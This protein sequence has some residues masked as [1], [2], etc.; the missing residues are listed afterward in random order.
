M[1]TGQP[2][3]WLYGWR[4]KMKSR[5]VFSWV[6][7]FCLSMSF[8]H[9]FAEDEQGFNLGQVVVTGTKTEHTLGEVPVAVDVVT[10]EDIKKRNVKTV[11][12]ALDLLTGLRVTKNSSSWGDKGH[13][14]MQG[15]DAKHTLVLIDGQRFTGGHGDAV[16]LQQI[17][18]DMI[19]RIEVVKG[20]ASALYG[21][22][23]VG[24]VVNVITKKASDKPFISTENLIGTRSTQKHSVTAGGSA[25]PVGAIV[26]YTYNE[27][28][29]VH[30]ETDKYQEHI[31]HG[32]VHYDILPEALTLTVKPYYSQHKQK[33]ERRKQER[34]GL[35]SLLEWSP[36]ELSKM[37]MRGSLLHY[38]HWDDDKSSNWDEDI[39]EGEINYSR[40]LFD[41]HTLMAGYNFTREDHIDKGK[42]YRAHQTTNSYFLQDEIALDPFTFIVGA[43]IDDHDKWDTQ[44]NPKFSMLYKVTDNFK[45][46]GSFGTA[47]RG[48]SLTKLYADGWRMGPY[49]VH[50]NANLKPEE[51]IGYQ[52]G[53][54][55]RFNNYVLAKVSYFR[56]EIENLITSNIVKAGPPPWDMYWI[57]VDEAMTQGVEVNVNTRF[58]ERLTANIGYTFLDTEDKNTNKDLTEKP[59]HKLTVDIGYM[60]PYIEVNVNVEAL[61][62]GRAYADA[63][64]EN[65]LGGY[66]IFNVAASKEFYEHAEVFA[67]IEN[68]TGKKNVYSDYDLDGTEFMGGVRLKF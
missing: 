52:V 63:E 22:E 26:N 25:G 27:S 15:L 58:F 14:Q 65:R 41:T 36:D 68:I 34:V 62:T 53:G 29:G 67:R 48:P 16:D 11:Q 12:E 4:L 60:I 19:D 10:Q 20:P 43:R 21:S 33:Y 5:S 47:F 1:L 30:K 31:V 6:L 61:Y 2:E 13:V 8:S 46:R 51:S 56:N 55:Y 66:T 64:N 35:N 42:D 44:I 28:S 32:S 45:L 9:A 39:Y 17:S 23:A 40:L 24:G 7:C 54:E 38:Q 18:L 50:S 57:N 3:E 49:S 37:T 59:E